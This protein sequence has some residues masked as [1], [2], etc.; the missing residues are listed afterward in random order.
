[1]QSSSKVS[2]NN[3]IPLHR[4]DD[5]F[6]KYPQLNLEKIKVGGLARKV[7]SNDKQPVGEP[8]QIKGIQKRSHKKKI[9]YKQITSNMHPTMYQEGE[10]CNLR[11]GNIISQPRKGKEQA[12]INLKQSAL[13]E[14]KGYRVERKE[15]D[16]SGTL[17]KN[18][19]LAINKQV[20]STIESIH[21][22]ASN[23][24]IPNKK[25]AKEIPLTFPI[26]I[27]ESIALPQI[28]DTIMT[29][30]AIAEVANESENTRKFTLN[31]T[32]SKLKEDDFPPFD[33]VKVKIEPVNNQVFCLNLPSI[34][35]VFEMAKVKKE[36]VET[37]VT[38]VQEDEVLADE[39][40]LN[41]DLNV[42]SA[43]PI[44]DSSIDEPEQEIMF[45]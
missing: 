39:T 23:T 38:V 11:Q 20:S 4:S 36:P 13:K 35:T 40:E 10:I 41:L 3:S 2:S 8:K 34:A 12:L 27:I 25:P 31:F 16:E 44:S 30:D 18:E 28:Y 9:N 14:A 37:N 29:E 43:I 19:K 17:T 22:H 45:F 33:R 6:F 32:E 24:I 1:M 21:R 42:L 5:D 15:V 7:I 26:N